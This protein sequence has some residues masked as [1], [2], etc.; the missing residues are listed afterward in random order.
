VELKPVARLD[1]P[2]P[3]SLFGAMFSSSLGFL[4]CF[5]I[6]AANIYAAYEVS[7]FRAQPRAL[8][9]GL[10]AIP[11]L[12]FFATA[13][14]LALPTRMDRSA[15]PEVAPEV[16]AA[17]AQV[18][19][20]PGTPSATPDAAAAGPA[21]GLR[22]SSAAAGHSTKSL[23]TTQV[24]PRGAFTFNRRFFET[25]FPGFFGVIRRD[26]DKDMVLV[27]KSVRGEYIGQRITRIAANDVH[28]HVQKG[29]VGEEIPISF[30]EIQEVR[31]KHKDA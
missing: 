9:C 18:Y 7:V 22:L 20:V 1:R 31:L 2:P 24:F 10:A 28:I 19:S 12:G 30:S 6:Y 17:A 23:P 5:L 25:K 27:V 21:S 8:V 3:R 13:V 4:L 26:A 29:P 11:F 16:V 15:A 14:F